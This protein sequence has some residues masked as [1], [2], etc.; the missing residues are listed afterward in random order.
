MLRYAA[1]S[2][3]SFGSG[4]LGVAQSRMGS[5]VRSDGCRPPQPT[6]LLNHHTF[7]NCEG[8]F[9]CQL[10]HI[11]TQHLARSFSQRPVIFTDSVSVDSKR[12]S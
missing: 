3:S 6:N 10:G 5:R 1:S 12:N 9:L 2:L 4:D 7:A 11:W 8:F